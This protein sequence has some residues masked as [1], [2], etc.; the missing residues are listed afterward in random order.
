MKE[1]SQH[2]VSETWR[3]HSLSYTTG[4]SHHQ[5]LFLPLPKGSMEQIN[6]Q[7]CPLPSPVTPSAHNP[8]LSPQ[9]TV[10]LLLWQLCG[11][12]S[13]S[14]H[15]LFCSS[16]RLLG[17]GFTAVKDDSVCLLSLPSRT[18]AQPQQGNGK[19]SNAVERA[20]WK[21]H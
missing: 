3:L 5:L 20:F 10:S 12:V 16:P 4:T 6:A 14:V 1:T 21:P 19:G 15:W 11:R 7:R 2:T 13:F 9:C 8:F 17:R 18:P